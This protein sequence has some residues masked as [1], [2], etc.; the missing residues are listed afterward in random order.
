[1]SIYGAQAVDSPRHDDTAQTY[2]ALLF[3]SFG[4][5]E[6]MDDVMPFNFVNSGF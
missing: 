6:G 5:P 3:L 2:D 1:M 4:G